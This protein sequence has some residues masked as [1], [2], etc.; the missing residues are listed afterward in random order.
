MLVKLQ[1]EHRQDDG[2]VGLLGREI[3]HGVDIHKPPCLRAQKEGAK[4]IRFMALPL[5]DF[6]VESGLAALEHHPPM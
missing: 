3:Q 5:A 6:E 4:K 2:R 1:D